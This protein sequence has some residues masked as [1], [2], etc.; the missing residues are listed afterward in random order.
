MFKDIK[1]IFNLV[2][3]VIISVFA[4]FYF[5]S[6]GVYPVDSFAFFDSAHSIING[7]IPFRDYWVMNGPILDLFQS[8]FFYFGGVS[9]KVYLLHSSFINALFAIISYFFFRDFG[10]DKNYSLTYTICLSLL[11][12]PVV[13]VP[14]PDHHSIIFS[15]IG[16]YTL[17]LA[18]KYDYRVFW[19]LLP[20]FF[21]IA[22]FSKQ[23]PAAYFI[24]LTCVVLFFYTFILKKYYWLV[25]TLL[26]SFTLILFLLILLSINNI[27]ILDLFTQYFLF[28]KTIGDYRLDQFS[29]S[30]SKILSNFKFIFL[31]LIILLYIFISKVSSNKKYYLKNESIF[32]L[33]M[34]FSIFISVFHQVLTK[35]QNFI[36]FTIPL[37]CGFSQC[38][39]DRNKKIVILILISL[40]LFTTIKYH[41]RFNIDR[42]FME[43]EHIDKNLFERGENI[44]TILKGLKWTNGEYI[45][46]PKDEVKYLRLTIDHLK[47]E[48]KKFIIITNYQFLLSSI[49]KQ[50]YSPNRW[51]TVD[52]VSYPLH[53]NKYYDYYKQFYNKKLK[54]KKIEIIYTVLPLNIETVD[55]LLKKNCISSTKINP[56]LYKHKLNG[57]Y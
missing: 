52:G 54:D 45:G 27:N 13:G 26:S 10:L 53:N 50:N 29:F 32:I 36:F 23:T 15:F 19:I 34:V 1:S 44:N 11:A 39:V 2:I 41:L 48:K 46:K 40:T 24:I 28:P 38:F 7:S 56:I 33:I 55:F 3:I 12:Y 47:N 22:F 21:F 25:F 9:W 43:L 30:S 5:G 20:I 51:Y 8:I 35:N 18:I 57:C 37:L 42:K 4:N 49:S 14:F 17:I 6:I 16:V 31:G